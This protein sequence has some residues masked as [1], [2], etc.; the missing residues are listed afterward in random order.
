MI[1]PSNKFV[2]LCFYYTRIICFDP[3]QSFDPGGRR[4]ASVR[5]RGKK[6]QASEDTLERDLVHAATANTS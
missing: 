2:L 6:A 3:V 1:L 5:I 4:R